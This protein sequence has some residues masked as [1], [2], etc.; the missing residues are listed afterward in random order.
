MDL[1]LNSSPC[2]ILM[3]VAAGSAACMATL[4]LPSSSLN[5]TFCNE[6]LDMRGLSVTSSARQRQLL[7]PLRAV[8]RGRPASGERGAWEE[9]APGE[10]GRPAR[11]R[12]PGATRAKK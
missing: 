2:I 1:T 12:R 9:T 7:Q 4:F 11:A 8:G 5:C 6:P 10:P 3:F